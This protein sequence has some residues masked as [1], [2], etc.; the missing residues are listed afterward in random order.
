MSNISY[1][2]FQKQDSEIWPNIFILAAAKDV[3]FTMACG[4]DGLL[5]LF[6]PI[7]RTAQALHD[8]FS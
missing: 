1:Y 8:F 3:A 7:H 4:G 5:A 6:V 2:F